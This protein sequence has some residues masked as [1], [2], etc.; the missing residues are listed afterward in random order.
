MT[1]ERRR[2]D[3][4]IPVQVRI[5][6]SLVERID[7]CARESGITRPEAVRAGMLAWCE[8]RETLEG[9]RRRLR[10]KT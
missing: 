5:Q 8:R 2:E 3:D 4:R 7:A 6:R 1:E 10:E 9:R